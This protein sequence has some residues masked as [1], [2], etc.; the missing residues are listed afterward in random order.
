MS[1]A[2]SRGGN[3]ASTRAAQL[4]AV[5]GLAAS[6]VGQQPF[7]VGT[8]LVIEHTGW[9]SFM[10]DPKD[11]AMADALALVPAR[12]RELAREVPDMPRE[13]PGLINMALGALSRPTVL[14]V[15]YNGENPSGGLFGYGVGIS[16]RMPD[17]AAS[18]DMHSAITGLMRQGNVQLKNGEGTRF[19]G[20]TD[21]Q[22]PVALM[23]FGPKK[24]DDGWR[25]QAVFGTLDDAESGLTALPKAPDGMKPIFR[26]RIDMAGL[27]PARDLVAGF[28]GNEPGLAEMFQSVEE[29]GIV[30]DQAMKASYQAGFTKDESGSVLVLEGAKKHAKALGMSERALG[31]NELASIPSD[32]TSVYLSRA[33]ESG[34]GSILDGFG[35]EQAK[36][37]IEQ[38]LAEFKNQ[39]G[40]DLRADVLDALGGAIG[41]YMSDA[42]G[43]G[44]MG[45]T[46]LLVGV[47]DHDRFAGTMSKLASMANALGDQLPI[48]PGYLRLVGW[49]DGDSDLW[50]LRFPGLPVP[51]ELTF[52]LTP[53]WL[54]VSPTPQGAVV[55]SRQA[56]GKGDKG[57]MSNPAIAGRFPEGKAFTGLSYSD[58][59]RTMAGGYT[60]LSMLGSAV[61]NAVRSPTDPG[62]EPGLLV[63]PFNDLRKGAKSSVSYTYWRGDDQVTETR[64]DRST[65]VAACSSLGSA[66]GLIPLFAAAAAVGVAQ[67]E[68]IGPFGSGVNPAAMARVAARALPLASRERFA[69]VVL[70]RNAWRV[71]PTTWT[72]LQ[73]RP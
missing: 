34:F 66:G 69:M 13:A 32:V 55:A 42:T 22:T 65:L 46:V 68:R 64:S 30:G 21:F 51:L 43:G 37:Q 2:T 5:L 4:A 50:T 38:G 19:A 23:S 57:M 26:A 49:K 45:S 1:K 9:D 59:P 6:A 35:Q 47:R 14:T 11:R 24:A 60:L 73:Q 53:N 16:M 48:G 41:Y 18:T 44:G 7:K 17:Q 36:E 27:T 54:M 58:S 3:R 63:P 31:K 67:E 33:G 52:A 39:T 20:M 70:S 40:I 29:L 15:A 56:T 8:V 72:L 12:V 25:Y 71:E 61:A 10:A 62:R 28:A